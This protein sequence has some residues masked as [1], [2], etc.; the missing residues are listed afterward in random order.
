MS[1]QRLTCP[2]LTT[3]LL[4]TAACTN[5][6]SIK[7][8][9]FGDGTARFSVY[10]ND[11]GR[12][13]ETMVNKFIDL[14]LVKIIDEAEQSVL[15]A[16]YN[17]N[18]QSI[19][20]AVLR[21]RE[22]NIEVKVVGDIDE[23]YTHG[24]QQ[25]QQ[26]NIDMSLGNASG[27]QH[28]KF[29]VVDGRLVFTGTGNL[30]DTDMDRN[31]NNW[32]IIESPE[33][34]N[35]YRN[36][37]M[38]MYSGL[39]ASKKRPRAINR[40]FTVNNHQ[41]EVYFSPYDGQDAMD[42]LIELVNSAQHSVHYMIFAHTHDELASAMIHAARQRNIPVYG[43]HDNTFVVGV[44]EEAPRIYTSAFNNDG[45]LHP[46]GP[47]P[48]WDGN[49]NTKIRGNPAHGG[50]MHCKTLIIDAGT[51]NA[52]M[53]TGSF[54][55]SN[56]AI[57]N[58]DENMIVIHNPKI[59]NTIYEQFK[60]AWGISNDLALR[61]GRRG[62][63]ANPGDIVISEINWAGSSTTS[64]L[65]QSDDFIE[66]YNKGSQPV[67]L[68]HWAIQWGPNEW[69][70]IYP[71]P[72]RHNWYYENK[73]TCSGYPGYQNF[74]ETVDNVI[75]PGMYRVFYAD[76]NSAFAPPTPDEDIVYNEDG[77]ALYTRVTGLEHF[78]ISGV[79]NFR[80]SNAQFKVRLFD[81]AMNLVDEA[82]D[83]FNAPAGAMDSIAKISRSM[84][85]RSHTNINMLPG[86]LKAA[87]FTAFTKY[88]CSHWSQTFDA[89]SN[90]AAGETYASAG[91]GYSSAAQ[92]RLLSAYL[93][94]PT[95]LILNFNSNMTNCMNPSF[96][97]L[98]NKIS[99]SGSVPT[100]FNLTQTSLGVLRLTATSGNFNGSDTLFSAA[101]TS[102]CQ[103]FWSVVANTDAL[104]FNGYNSSRAQVLLNRVN[105]DTNWI[106]IR[107]TSAGTVRGL[108]VFYYNY[109]GMDLVHEFGELSVAANDILV[110]STRR[111]EANLLKNED[112]YNANGCD[113]GF[114]SPSCTPA[115]R[116]GSPY[117]INSMAP[118]LTTTDAVIILTYCGTNTENSAGCPL[119]NYGVQDVLYY[120]NRDG[121]WTGGFAEGAL[122]EVYYNLQNFW[123]LSQLP[124]AGL[125]DRDLQLEGICVAADS[126]ASE[127]ATYN[128]SNSCKG[129]MRVN[130]LQQ[131]KN[132]WRCETVLTRPGY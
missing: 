4:L 17:F 128:C 19:I 67:D 82:G 86:Y 106:E 115:T 102:S 3:V 109:Q 130:D 72:D 59:A 15:L 74:S 105:N 61:V 127:N 69:R 93:T 2:L 23:F 41:I 33:I 101:P 94:S 131:G 68:S 10:F 117:H 14:E 103:D 44:S 79:K 32:Y 97:I 108:R 60:Q 111:S 57:N 1:L 58:N 24:Y 121:S 6:T 129:V 30:S 83:G 125:N 64:N 95:E 39:F 49:E 55:W 34:A 5:V 99:G 132:S 123:P 81:K 42:R 76:G 43:I 92:P 89:C 73:Q 29:A 77:A 48:R 8:P 70:N 114:S 91:T 124:V 75:C 122:R 118:T 110:V 11:P 22:R 45:S 80:L 27:I 116:N 40:T 87:W 20:D 36:E 66:I 47:F 18:K 16:V 98:L 100:A 119:P 96:D 107:A 28:N 78:R 56:N 85:R 31:N 120:T 53:A 113:T 51:P 54:N 126:L 12:D 90:A 52:K 104:Y 35:H 9:G 13:P 84:E 50:K 21:A 65:K 25:M 7:D 112:T 63:I 46:T 37:F 26:Y 38:Q 71:I 88:T 62:H